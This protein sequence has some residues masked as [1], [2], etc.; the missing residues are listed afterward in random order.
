M[1]A[2]RAGRCSEWT[3]FGIVA[4]SLFIIAIGVTLSGCTAA[5]LDQYAKDHPKAIAT[6]Q[7]VEAGQQK[8]DKAAEAVVQVAPDIRRIAD[9][10]DKMG[11]PGAKWIELIA[12]GASAA[13]AGWLTK[14]KV[15]NNDIATAPGAGV[16]ANG[17]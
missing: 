17:G 9:A 14:R 6:T 8:V 2:H 13:A 7:A 12:V 4:V 16:D 11:V 15:N 1:K 5:Q 3:I 10:A